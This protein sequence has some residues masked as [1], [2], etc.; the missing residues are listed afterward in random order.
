MEYKKSANVLKNML[1]KRLFDA[2]EKDALETAIGFL[3]WG[4]LGTSRLKDKKAKKEKSTK[5]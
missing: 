3:L 2:E 4:A 5:W 1:D